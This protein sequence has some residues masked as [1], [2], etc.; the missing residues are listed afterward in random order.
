[1]GIPFYDLSAVG[2]GVP[3]GI[4]WI[5]SM[6]QFVEIKNP[7]TAYGRRGLNKIQ[8]KWINQWQGGDVYIIRTIDDAINFSR[9]DLEKVES[10]KSN[11]NQ[12]EFYAKSVL[13]LRS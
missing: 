10:I 12:Q 1:M 5:K 4:A 6:W 13:P 8:K 3:D 2:G 9:G 7:K 11:Y